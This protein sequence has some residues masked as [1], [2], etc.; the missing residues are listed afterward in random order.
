MNWAMVA[1]AIA[2]GFFIGNSLD[3]RAHTSAVPAPASRPASTTTTD[4]LYIHNSIGGDI[5]VFQNTF[6]QAQRE[7]R[8]I[9]ISGYCYSACTLALG[10]GACVMSGTR[11]G[12]H[13]ATEYGPG[14]PMRYSP[15]GTATVLDA[16]PEEIRHK[17]R[18]PLTESLQYITTSQIPSRYLCPTSPSPMMAEARPRRR[19]WR[20]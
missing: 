18:L 6:A 12:Y 1:I 8:Q 19:R 14:I 16:T 15:S 20:P 4:A 10:Y 7:G 2:I 5:E 13:A 3:H 11:L 17:L 9:I